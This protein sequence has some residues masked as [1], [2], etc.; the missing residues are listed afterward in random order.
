ML[1]AFLATG[2]AFLRY[3]FAAA[4]AEIINTLSTKIISYKSPPP[5]IRLHR[6]D[7]LIQ[8]YPILTANLSQIKS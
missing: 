4:Y 2:I 7:A 3:N 5:F 8:D 1:N 6:N